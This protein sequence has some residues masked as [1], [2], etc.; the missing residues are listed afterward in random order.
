MA[1]KSMRGEVDALA[2]QVRL[3]QAQVAALQVAASARHC[4]GCSCVHATWITP[5]GQPQPY[6]PFRVTC[7]TSA[8]VVTMSTTAA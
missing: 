2:E 3:L 8:N 5:Y 1:A 4:H 7:G 6:E